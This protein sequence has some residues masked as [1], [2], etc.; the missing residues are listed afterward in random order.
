MFK[1]TVVQAKLKI[2]SP[3]NGLL[4]VIFKDKINEQNITREMLQT[5]FK[6]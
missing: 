3:H 6:S 1:N 5:E 4:K 2:V